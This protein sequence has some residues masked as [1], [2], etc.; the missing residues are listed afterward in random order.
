MLGPKAI[1]AVLPGDVD[2]P[3]DYDPADIR[4][5][6]ITWAVDTDNVFA[7]GPSTVDPRSGEIL[8]SSIVLTNGYIQHYVKMAE[9]FEVLGEDGRRI[10]MEVEENLSD[11]N[12]H[13]NSLQNDPI[14]KQ[15]FVNLYGDLLTSRAIADHNDD[16]SGSHKR[17]AA[18]ESPLVPDDILSVLPSL[19]V[20][21]PPQ[22]PEWKMASENVWQSYGNR[23]SPPHRYSI[24]R[25]NHHSPD[26]GFHQ[27]RGLYS[28]AILE[29]ILSD[30]VISQGI[31]STV[32]HEV[33]HTLGLRHNFKG[34]T[35]YSLS[36]L[37]DP[38][39]TAKHG[40]SLSVMDYLPLNLV[41][42]RFRGDDNKA[43]DL[44]STC[45][46]RYD[47]WA[48]KYGYMPLDD[49]KNG[50]QE[51]LFFLHPSLEEIT[52][53]SEP[54]GTDE[55]ERVMLRGGSDPFTNMYDLGNDPL[56]YYLDTIELMK[57]I[58]EEGMLERAVGLTDPF[59]FYGDFEKYMI[60]K[61]NYLGH[62][63]AKY[64]GGFSLRKVS[65]DGNVNRTSVKE[66]DNLGKTNGGIVPLEVIDIQLQLNALS[67]IKR[68]LVYE[69]DEGLW[70]DPSLLP[71]MVTS[72]GENCN[73]LFPYCDGL[74]P[75]PFQTT[76]NSVRKKVLSNLVDSIRLER[77][78]LQ[79]WAEE[80]MR[81]SSSNDVNS[82]ELFGPGDLI[83]NVTEMLW[84]TNLTESGRVRS[85]R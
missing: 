16:V 56:A 51:P 13:Q 43:A 36:D 64:V 21:Q 32:M 14:P 10:Q 72:S 55:D 47:K 73:G 57:E 71:Y 40:L 63:I 58:R 35:A 34:S 41:S 3:S 39:F 37:Q 1:R 5:N 20:N 19:I 26:F 27:N 31:T 49:V 60:Q 70:P 53:V 84:G 11:D 62:Y 2:W 4:F 18:S 9:N 28:G 38:E 76:V 79:Y 48:I 22:S 67:A 83:H 50:Q 85:T 54:Y 74:I 69:A 33:G 75:Y 66:E 12:H 52:A 24:H 65:R 44:F 30:E 7:I 29:R 6:A 46:G 82:T 8:R 81:R 61:L 77:L 17:C 15:H 23:H 59:T 80:G 45:I 25:H 42:K 68:I 78:Q